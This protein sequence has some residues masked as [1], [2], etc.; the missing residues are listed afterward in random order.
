MNKNNVLPF[1]AIFSL[2]CL[3]FSEFLLPDLKINGEIVYTA[4]FFIVLYAIWIEIYQ[5]SGDINTFFGFSELSSF[6]F[7]YKKLEFL[8]LNLISV[9]LRLVNTILG[10]FFLTFV[11][12]KSLNIIKI[13]FLSFKSSL[14]M[15]NK[16]KL[17][18]KSLPLQY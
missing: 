10:I 4:G 14:Q 8:F 5:A 9:K 13:N 3:V 6:W 11:I 15:L 1:F 18:I 12:L 2:L 17:K 16:I 7:K